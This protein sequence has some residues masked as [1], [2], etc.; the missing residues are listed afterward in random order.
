MNANDTLRAGLRPA[1]V[2]P[3]LDPI[4]VFSDDDIHQLGQ[5]M[6]EG[7]VAVMRDVISA[8]LLEETRV[9]VEDQLARRNREYLGIANNSW[10]LDS[11]L[12]GVSQSPAMQ[13]VLT[14]LY[15]HAMKKAPLGARI[16][17]SIRALSGKTGLN[18]SWLFHYDSYVVTALI[19][20]LIPDAPDELPGDLVLYPNL[21]RER[22][23]AL[24]NI[25]EKAIVE[26]ALARKVWKSERV[27][28]LASSKTLRMQ[29]GNVYLFWGMRSLH[30]NQPCLPSSVR[31]TVLFH[32]GDPHAGG[33]L[34][35]L[36]ARRHQARLQKLNRKL[37]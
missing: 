33:F 17:P 18:H 11:P 15:T 6:D 2:A 14:R 36:S 5:S 13:N 30:A 24:V 32:F 3:M 1:P 20:I 25:V 16:A 9:Y 4:R 12:A 34:K 19:P 26:S 27:Q 23:W 22:R 7:G 8:E 29:P 21:R 31:C 37:E 28:R 10:I 35:R